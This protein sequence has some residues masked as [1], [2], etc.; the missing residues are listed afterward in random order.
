MPN[1]VLAKQGAVLLMG[2]DSDRAGQRA[3]GDFLQFQVV[4]L[5]GQTIVVRGVY[6]DHKSAPIP[7]GQSEPL[8]ALTHAAVVV[9]NNEYAPLIE[10]FAKVTPDTPLRVRVAFVLGGE[11][12]ELT[13]Y[14][15]IM[16]HAEAGV[17]AFR[18]DPAVAGQYRP[19]RAAAPAS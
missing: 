11:E 1:Q 7:L 12:L 6:F 16:E 9:P 8:T 17:R 19:V 5:S 18:L 13:T 10:V 2:M 14:G 4:N 3:G 15:R